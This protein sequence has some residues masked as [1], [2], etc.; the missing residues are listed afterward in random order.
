MA[1]Q[2]VDGLLVSSAP[3]I[4][5]LSNFS[6]FSKEE[7]E[8]F[9]FLTKNKQYIL[10]STLN[11][12]AVKNDV[13]DFK[14]LEYSAKN[15]LAMIL[16]TLFKKHKVKTLGLETNDITLFEKKYLFSR[17]DKWKHFSFTRLREIKNA[18][19]IIAI[20]NACKITDNAFEHVLGKIKPG[21][22]EL[23]VAFELEMH[24]KRRGFD[25]AFPSIVAFGKNA[26]RPH[27]KTSNCKLKPN[28]LILLDF[29]AKANN[30][31]ADM[32]RTCFMGKTTLKQKK[33]YK[34]VLGAQQKA[35]EFLTRQSSKSIKAAEVDQVARDYIIS[36]GYPSIPHS[37]G[38]GIG[39]AVHEHP[40]LS[41]NSKD[42]LKKNMV[43]SIEPGIYL[44]AGDAGGVRIEDLI[45]LTSS[46]PK[47]L[48][49]AA[50]DLIEL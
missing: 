25:L 38:H 1:K 21:I 17:I 12:T 7:R 27:H 41:P 19:E 32:S 48:S 24:I 30:Y 4:I 34:A 26:S 39:L 33:I 45:L 35:I 22:T 2:H 8:G 29:G 11:A 44:P 43:F 15:T 9:L 28:D 13:K 16:V 10:T 50:K 14:L 40:R 49:H 18:E 47:L 31:C 46:G 37:L 36:Q 20:E 3:N 42:T 6:G 23:D 5:Y